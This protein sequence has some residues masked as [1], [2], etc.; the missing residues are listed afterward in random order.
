[1]FKKKP[2]TK[3]EFTLKKIKNGGYI[4]K[5]MD[6]GFLNIL[7]GRY[8]LQAFT[9]YDEVINAIIKITEPLI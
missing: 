2:P 5:Y 1:M 8:H 7:F 3:I 9:T 4:L 6:I